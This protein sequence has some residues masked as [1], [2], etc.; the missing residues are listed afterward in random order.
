MDRVQSSSNT[1]NN[2]VSVLIEG[3]ECSAV[4]ETDGHISLDTSVLD[5]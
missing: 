3:P 2:L 4:F 5:V 1:F